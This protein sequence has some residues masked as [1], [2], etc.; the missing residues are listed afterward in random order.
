MP[1]TTLVFITFH[2]RCVAK[3]TSCMPSCSVRSGTLRTTT[4]SPYGL[5]GPIGSAY[6]SVMNTVL[7]GPSTSRSS[8]A[9]RK[10]WW[11][12][13]YVRSSTSVPLGFGCPGAS[14]VVTM[15]PVARTSHSML[16]SW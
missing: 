4:D 15:M 14:G 16:P 9:T 7:S 12:G 8:R 13:A 5:S 10:C 2:A 6:D 1:L 11:K 3:S